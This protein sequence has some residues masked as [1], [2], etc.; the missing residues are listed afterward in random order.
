MSISRHVLDDF[1]DD[2]NTPLDLLDKYF[3][4]PLGSFRLA[5]KQSHFFENTQSNDIL[6]TTANDHQIIHISPF[7]EG[8]KSA[9]T[10]SSSSIDMYSPL[11]THDDV[12]M[13]KGLTTQHILSS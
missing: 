5:R 8:Q 1:I 9:L 13:K 3:S 12:N 10:I 2:N 6:L 7:N 4:R 11:Y